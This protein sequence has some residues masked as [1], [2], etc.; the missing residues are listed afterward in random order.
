MNMLRRIVGVG[1]P[2]LFRYRHEPPYWQVRVSDQPI[3]RDIFWS[4]SN[5]EAIEKILA[6][7]LGQE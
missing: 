2:K 7:R 1:D 4:W 3:G 6:L 5:D